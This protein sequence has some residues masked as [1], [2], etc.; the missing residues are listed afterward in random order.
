MR[1]VLKLGWRF[2]TV[3]LVNSL[4]LLAAISLTPGIMIEATPSNVLTAIGFALLIGLANGFVRP[5]L[6]YLTYPVNLLTIGIPT[7]LIDSALF[8]LL[9]NAWRGFHM[10]GYWPSA[11]IGA[12]ILPAANILLST[13]TD[14]KR[15][16]TLYDAVLRR[17]GRRDGDSRPP[18]TGRGVIFVQVDGLSYT[19]L[20]HALRNGYLSAVEELLEGD[21]HLMLAWDCGIPS[22]T[23]SVQAGIMYGDNNDI[24]AFRWFDRQSGRIIVSNR[25]EGAQAI[26]SRLREGRA[27]LLVGGSSVSNVLTG[28]ARTHVLTVSAI[29][30]ADSQRVQDLLLFLLN[31][32]CL[33]RV[34]GLLVVDL[35]AEWLAARRQQLR[36]DPVRVS[37]RGLYPFMR[38]MTNVVLREISTYLVLLDI[39]RGVPAIYVTY[40]G[41]DEIAHFTG[42]YSPDVRSPLA[43]IDSQIRHIDK[44]VRRDAPMPYDLFVLS[45]H[46]QTPSVPFSQTAGGS[47][48]AL[49]RDLVRGE[50]AVSAG[51][52]TH[53]L[54]GPLLALI[55]E[56]R[57]VERLT[58]GRLAPRAIGRGRRALQRYG[59]RGLSP[60]EGEAGA[61]AGGE[62]DVLVLA[63]G[64]AA[65]LYFERQGEGLT[66][67]QL[68][69]RHP[70]LVAELAQHAGVGFVAGRSELR[71]PLVIGQGGFRQLDSGIVVGADPLAPFG[72][73][74]VVAEQ[75]LRLMQFPSSGDL[76]VHGAYREGRVVTFE[77]HIGS[78]GGLGGAQTQ[79]FLIY[80]SDMRID[81]T[82]IS[83]AVDLYPLFQARRDEADPENPTRP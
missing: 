19:A 76:V 74:P 51:V 69:Q 14:P 16:R 7:I 44:I 9:A 65:H 8:I 80:P 78:H 46:G 49:V 53:E 70:L 35:I 24:P 47:L 54:P 75:L 83:N 58:P 36:R 13:L 64:S 63:S 45:D 52:A 6:V 1:R 11:V 18:A 5:V 59:E 23:S 72:D 32:Y 15:Q 60:A 61:P 82:T 28:S 26:E 29:G 50:M 33:L 38:A 73:P 4:S 42:P 71:G 48:Q 27:G 39:M 57:E 41:Y 20:R 31:P 30:G 10:D 17:L 37:R 79:P 25:P 81:A 56:L 22:Q 67:E 62:G 68:E 12:V 66:L 55:E 43:G 3:G 34:A 21:D 77:E 2:F 40:L